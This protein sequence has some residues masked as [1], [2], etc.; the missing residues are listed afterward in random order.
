[1]SD[2]GNLFENGHFDDPDRFDVRRKIDRHLA[3]GYGAH[4]C[5]GAAL[6]RLEG[7]I[8]LEQTLDRFDVHRV[9]AVH[10]TGRV[11]VGEASVMVAAPAGH[12]WRG[13]T[14]VSLEELA[15]EPIVLRE[16]VSGTRG[17][18][19]AAA[20]Q[21]RN[22]RETLIAVARE[23]FELAANL[24]T[25]VP[26]AF[27]EIKAGARAEEGDIIA[28]CREHLAGFKCPKS[29]EFGELPKTATGKIQK[30]KLRE[31]ARELEA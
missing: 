21:G 30:F 14:E 2:P 11:E 31:R 19:E 5:I 24:R 6:A 16:P 10:R 23:V 8:A 9:A 29:V 28:F 4:F 22:V 7:R 18:F 12:R 17:E 13:R 25:G 1:M 3:F 26:V 20:T 27:V 15:R